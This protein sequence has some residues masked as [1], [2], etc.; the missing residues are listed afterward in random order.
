MPH[1]RLKIHI[2]SC[3][4]LSSQQHCIITSYLN[5]DAIFSSMYKYLYDVWFCIK[6]AKINGNTIYL[7]WPDRLAVLA[8][9]AKH[10]GR[11]SKLK[12][13]ATPAV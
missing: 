2:S 3:I 10:S 12:V 11:I 13:S 9:Q 5:L 8:Q 1:K 7:P 4:G 6:F